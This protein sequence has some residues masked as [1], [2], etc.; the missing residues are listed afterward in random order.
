M[1]GVK[2]QNNGI[3]LNEE[4]FPVAIV[5]NW[6]HQ[7]TEVVEVCVFREQWIAPTAER[8]KGML[9]KYATITRVHKGTVKVGERVVL[10]SLFEFAAD[11]WK[12]E[13][14]LRPSRVSM[15]DGEL[16]VSMFSKTDTKKEDGYWDVG[17]DI[18]RFPLEGEFYQA[19]LFEKKRDSTLKGK[20]H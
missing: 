15:V 17:D 13:S 12:R 3:E 16:M 18:C 14:R 19:F 1:T 2:A 9:L 6:L 7:N 20:S 10:T 11:S 5:Q 8:P 4:L